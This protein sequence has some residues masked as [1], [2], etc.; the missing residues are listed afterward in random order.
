M[1]K[2]AFVIILILT[3]I[4]LAQS[5][6]T[7]PSKEY[8]KHG[9]VW[10]VG[11]FKAWLVD[12]HVEF[13]KIDDSVTP[14]FVEEKKSGFAFQSHYMYK[15]NKWLGIGAHAGLGLDVSSY[16]EA[17]VVLFGLSVS[18]GKD[19]QCIID[20]GLADGKRRIVPD[21]VRNDLMSSNLTDIPDIYNQ[22]EFNTGYYIGVSYR[23]F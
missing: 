8:E 4:S 9:V 6:A 20:F 7:K 2:I 19:H 15:P 18:I 10:S 17:P 1:Q 14:I 16:I 22:T 21:G 11:L 12:T 5:Q 23:V 3:S 13:N